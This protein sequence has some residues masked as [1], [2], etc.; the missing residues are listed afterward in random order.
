MPTDKMD[1]K[2]F[3]AFKLLNRHNDLVR[4]IRFEPHDAVTKELIFR[5]TKNLIDNELKYFEMKSLSVMITELVDGLVDQQAMPDDS[6][7][8]ALTEILEEIDR[9]EKKANQKNG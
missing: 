2:L 5:L 6:W 3:E 8:P 4:R 7:K 9:L 1:E